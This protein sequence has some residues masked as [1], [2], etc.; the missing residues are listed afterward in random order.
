M[1]IAVDSTKWVFY[2]SG[3]FAESD[4]GFV[5]NHAVLLVGYGEEDGRRY[6]KIR[7]SWGPLW[8]EEGYI[9]IL[10]RDDAIP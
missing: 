8:G 4:A 10:R 9:R 2:E 1:T 5:L 7:N 3:I 6:W